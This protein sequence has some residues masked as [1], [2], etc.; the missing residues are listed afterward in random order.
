MGDLFS[1]SVLYHNSK[2]RGSYKRLMKRSEEGF[3]G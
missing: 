2:K 1:D 3:G